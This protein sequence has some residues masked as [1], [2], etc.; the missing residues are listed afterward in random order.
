MNKIA[1]IYKSKY[2]ATKKYALMLQ[3]EL[4]CDI[5]DSNNISK[6]K[7]EQYDSVIFAGGIYASGIAGLKTLRKHYQTL[8]GKRLAI[9]GVGASPHDQKAFDELKTHNLKD[10]LKAIPLFYGRGGWN[11]S[12][13]S[14]K[15]RTLCKMLKKMVSKQDP[16]SYEP[17][18]EALLSAIGQECDW[19]DK[20]YII[21][22]IEYIK[23]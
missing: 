17:W 18:Q 12:K 9:L 16:D 6:V 1:V 8:K 10:D 3:E 2:G 13:M 20:K 21:P 5:Y 7:F 23:S 4:A 11:E 15:D 19:T 14:F 22:L